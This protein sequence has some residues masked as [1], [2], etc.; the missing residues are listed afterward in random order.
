M[1]LRQMTKREVITLDNLPSQSLESQVAAPVHVARKLTQRDPH[2]DGS[3]L[4]V[5]LKGSGSERKFFKQLQQSR[6]L[7]RP[8]SSKAPRSSNN[9][10]SMQNQ[11]KTS[12]LSDLS[13]LER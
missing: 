5:Q 2:Y 8:K 6:S 1:K 10:S 7:E 11:R 12:E 4:K 3:F 9:V 13:G